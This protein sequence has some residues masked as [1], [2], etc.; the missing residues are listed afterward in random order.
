VKGWLANKRIVVTGGAGFLGSNVV[1]NLEE[2][3]CK[4]I[5]IPRSKDYNLVEMEGVRR[6]YRD[7]K[8]D[9]VIHLAARVGGIGAN[10]RNPGSFFYENLMMGVQLIEQGRLS[11][12]E[13]FVAIGTICAYPKFTPVPF[14]EENLWNG[15]P[16]E[17]NAPYGLAKKML[18][19]QAQAYRQQYGFNA[20][21][22]LP[23][24]LYGPG[25]NFDPES[26]HVIPALIK[27]VFDAKEEGEKRIVAWGSGKPT[28]EF[29]YV[30]DAAEGI[31]LATEKYNKSEP[32]N[33]GAGF[34]ISIKDLAEMIC[35]LAG[36]HGKIE[37]DTSKPDGQPRRRLDTGRA[38]K[39]FDFEAKTDFREG[40]KRTI[41]WY[42]KEVRGDQ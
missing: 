31:V 18:L 24:N 41:E 32:V 35:E 42:K 29:I 21:Y 14:K 38:R 7:A 20:I 40:L 27:K 25:E 1:R 37:W 28:R 8:P 2:R 4:Q 9:I 6:L 30:E 39:E 34:E 3:G 19:V 36:F 10:M 26:S 33:L 11:G 5:F 13:K 17:T 16:E 15:Y 23:V 12:I 22:L